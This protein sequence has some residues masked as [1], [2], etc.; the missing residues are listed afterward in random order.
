M[1]RYTGPTDRVSRR[2][3]K[4][5]FLK[6]ERSQGPKNP[7][8]RRA[9]APGQH[10]ASRKRRTRTSEYGTQL[11]E[12]QN[13]KAIYGILERQFRNYYQ[14]ATQASGASGEALLQL[15]ELRLDNAV[16]R[17]GLADS[18]PQARQYVNHGHVRVNGAKVDIPSY[19]VKPGQTIELVSILRKP[20]QL[21]IP[22]WL[23]RSQ[24]A[25]AG[26]ILERPARDQIPTEIEEQLII[27]F[28]SR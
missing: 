15:L 22:V 19:Q 7:M 26:E 27:E 5:L 13:A 23:K 16:Y 24:S 14:K 8:T 25:L 18:R 2:A 20:T 6:G 11:R 9:Y 3:G 1:A 21:E 12:K 17:L 28:Y 4:N 10:G